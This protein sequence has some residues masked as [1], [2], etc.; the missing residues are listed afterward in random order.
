[1]IEPII[2]IP[3]RLAATRFPNKPLTKIM[4]REMILRVMDQAYKTKL[5]RVVVC[6]G[7]WEIH[8]LILKNGGESVLTDPDLPSGTDRIAAGLNAIDPMKKYKF[9]INLQGDLPVVAPKILTDIAH[10]LR[11]NNADIVTAVVPIHDN[12]EIHNPNIV[13]VALE[14]DHLDKLRGNA[15]YF[16]RLAIPWQE[17][18]NNPQFYHHIGIYG[19]LRDSLMKFVQLPPAFIEKSEKLEQL[20]ALANGMNIRIITADSAP[21]SVD[22]PQDLD[23]VNE[24]LKNQ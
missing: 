23:K 24:F 17:G 20:R 10:E 2:L 22:S 12:E 6:A 8:D 16:S 18:A 13:K 4:G 1:M 11:K 21:L 19:F 5:G 14:F 9:I 3:S 7:D 15:L